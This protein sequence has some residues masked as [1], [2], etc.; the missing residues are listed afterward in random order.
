MR[1]SAAGIRRSPAAVANVFVMVNVRLQTARGRDPPGHFRFPFDAT[2]PAICFGFGL[3]V[4]RKLSTLLLRSNSGGDS[5][6]SPMTH[7][8]H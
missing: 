6:R 7:L 2:A 5:V 8:R 1:A 3:R 4:N